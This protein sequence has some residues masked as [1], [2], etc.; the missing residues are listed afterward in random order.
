MLDSS[1]AFLRLGNDLIVFPSKKIHEK[2]GPAL[3][4]AVSEPLIIGI[5]GGFILRGKANLLC[6]RP[7]ILTSD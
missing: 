5:K 6:Q 7:R 1:S 3:K 4:W 2:G